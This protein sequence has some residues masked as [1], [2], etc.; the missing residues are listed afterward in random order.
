LNV[1]VDGRRRWWC[2]AGKQVA[3]CEGSNSTGRHGGILPAAQ[4]T[5]RY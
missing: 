2:F 1:K 4:P 3:A 5:V